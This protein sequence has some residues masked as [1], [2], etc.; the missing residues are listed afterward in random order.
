VEKR[1]SPEE[2]KGFL[3]TPVNTLELSVRTANCCNNEKIKYVGDLIQRTEKEL[4]SAKNFGR[5]SLNEVKE[6]LSK[7]NLKLGMKITDWESIPSQELARRMQAAEGLIE[8]SL[9]TYKQD[10]RLLLKL[11]RKVK[12]FDLSFKSLRCLNALKIVYIADLIQL[13]SRDLLKIRSFG[14]KSLT[15]IEEKLAQM[16]LRLNTK[17]EGWP[18]SNLNALIKENEKELEDERKAEAQQIEKDIRQEKQMERGDHT[19]N[20]L[21]SEE[22]I[23]LEDYLNYL[24]RLSKGE[25]D[26][27]IILTYYGW[28]GERPKTLEYTGRNYDL[29][30][31][32]VRQIIIKF[33]N[34]LNSLTKVKIH[35]KSILENI[36]K[37]IINMLPALLSE[38]KTVLI[39]NKIIYKDFSIDILYDLGRLFNLEIPFKGINIRKTH[40]L[41][42]SNASTV[43]KNVIQ[44]AKKAIEHNGVATIYDITAQVNME[45][46][47]PLTD[48]FTKTI[49][50]LFNVKWLDEATG[51]FWLTDISR[52]RLLNLIRKILSVSGTIE[53]SNL[54][55]GIKRWHRMAGFAPPKRVLLELCRQLSWCNVIGE[56][57]MADPPIDWQQE[58]KGTND[59]AMV[60]VLREYGPIMTSSDFEKKCLEI[61]VNRNSFWQ[62]L[63]FSPFIAR[64]DTNIYGLRGSKVSPAQIAAL[65]IKREPSNV[66]KDYGWTEDGEIWILLRISNAMLRTGI[67]NIPSAMKPFLQGDYTLVTFE[68]QQICPIKIN[69]YSG[70]SLSNLFKRRGGESNDYL[71]LLFNIQSRKVKASIEDKDIT[72]SLESAGRDKEMAY[73]DLSNSIPL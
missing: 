41:I 22:P 52:N 67:F 27:K 61:G 38:V 71:Y 53:V 5:K 14:R 23:Y 21:L 17:I 54:R 57:I 49:L 7:L 66:I 26:R 8:E 20:L 55:S 70:W 46:K 60:A 13:K 51:W 30:R 58:L 50:S 72:F 31:E 42:P 47:Y 11:I 2:L 37:M 16:D 3:H 39:K 28:D 29:T 43:V 1:L 64:F 36:L 73:S 32:R 25:R 33:E 10:K 34:Q 9:L 59:W 19:T 35:Y 24:S 6:L 69:G 15:E 45:S 44:K 56:I 68:G 4:I 40:L 48:S 62:H 65:K 63:S 12:E 18:P